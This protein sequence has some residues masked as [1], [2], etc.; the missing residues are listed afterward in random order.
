MYVYT[1]MCEF[2]YI[3]LYTTQLQPTSELLDL[4]QK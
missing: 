1:N 4:L 3:Y 2:I